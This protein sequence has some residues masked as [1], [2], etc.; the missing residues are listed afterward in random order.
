M[1][2][3]EY[4]QLV[5]ALLAAIARRGSLRPGTPAHWRAECEARALMKRVA[6]AAPVPHPEQLA[7]RSQADVGGPSLVQSL[8]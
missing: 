1:D 3:A 2:P 5:E 7:G 4:E 8:D 6:A